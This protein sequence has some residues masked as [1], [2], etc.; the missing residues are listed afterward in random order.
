MALSVCV[1]LSVCPAIRCQ[2]VCLAIRLSVCLFNCQIAYM[3]VC[4]A[5]SL[6]MYIYLSL[7]LSL[8]PSLPPSLFLQF[9]PETCLVVRPPL[10]L[11]SPSLSTSLSFRKSIRPFNLAI[12]NPNKSTNYRAAFDARGTRLSE[13]SNSTRRK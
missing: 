1:Y 12:P 11:S 7:F 2:S 9:F 13:R 8:S 10:S 4:L 5:L 6:F 3:S